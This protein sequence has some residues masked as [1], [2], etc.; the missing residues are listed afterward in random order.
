MNSLLI[1]KRTVS[2]LRCALWTWPYFEK[3]VSQNDIV[4][5]YDAKSAILFRCIFREYYEVVA[6]SDIGET[7]INFGDL[8]VFGILF[9]LQNFSVTQTKL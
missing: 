6:D 1:Y 4:K 5:L 2:L 8:P 9:I 3:P 7:L